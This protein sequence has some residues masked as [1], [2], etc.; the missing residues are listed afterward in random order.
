MPIFGGES[1]PDDDDKSN[2]PQ[3]LAWA[4]FVLGLTGAGAE[5]VELFMGP[6]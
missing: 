5:L 6:L 3:W 4:L 1:D 2:G